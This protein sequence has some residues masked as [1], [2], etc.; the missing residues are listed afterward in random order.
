[1]RNSLFTVVLVVADLFQPVGGL[2][3]E[4]FHNGNVRHGRG[5]RSAVP[6]LLTRR[7]PD[8]IAGMDLLN[9]TALT[10]DPTAT[11]CDNQGLTQRVG[12]PCS[13]GAG[14]ECDTGAAHPC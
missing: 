12:V 9:W 14:F 5:G 3:V 4:L 2:A 8:H 7:E 1:M 11:G 6:M 10:L 13:T